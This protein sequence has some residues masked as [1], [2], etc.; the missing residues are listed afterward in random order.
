[1]SIPD[2]ETEFDY[3]GG[4]APFQAGGRIGLHHFYFR[5]R[6]DRWHFIVAEQ[7]AVG[8][9][10]GTEPVLFERTERY[11]RTGGYTASTMSE[12]VA[13][14]IISR[15]ICAYLLSSSSLKISTAQKQGSL[16]HG[17]A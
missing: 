3:F 6:G 8:A 4:M 7:D 14:D 12:K 1:M 10:C 2:A 16:E 17:V 9:F 5:A 15:C 13:M 11:G